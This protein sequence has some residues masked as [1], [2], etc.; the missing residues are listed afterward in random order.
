MSF[1]QRV[2]RRLFPAAWFAAM[3]AES[4]SWMVR[5][6][7]GFE[8][9]VWELGGIRWK[10]SGQPRRRM[11]CIHCGEWTWHRIYQKLAE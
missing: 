8:R 1:V 11:R 10:A 4:L 2:C 5:C 7:C 6:S 3:R 9:S